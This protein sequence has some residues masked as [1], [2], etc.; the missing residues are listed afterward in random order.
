VDGTGGG[1][2]EVSSLYSIITGMQ[3]GAKERLKAFNL[4]LYGSS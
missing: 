2:P 3:E 1:G 4:T